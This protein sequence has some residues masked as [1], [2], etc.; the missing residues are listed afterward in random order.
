MYLLHLN[1]S[2]LKEF[3]K[4]TKLKAKSEALERKWSYAE[5]GPCKEGKNSGNKGPVAAKREKIELPKGDEE[6]L[7]GDLYFSEVRKQKSQGPGVRDAGQEENREDKGLRV[8]HSPQFSNA[9]CTWDYT[10][11]WLMILWSLRVYKSL[12]VTT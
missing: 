11:N 5:L 7:S 3:F 12:Q 6:A 2:H 9:H 4:E 1:D 8:L 10:L